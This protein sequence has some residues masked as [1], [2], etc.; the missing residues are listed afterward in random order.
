MTPRTRRGNL[1]VT[2]APSYAAGISDIPLLGETIGDNLARTA[3]QFA[4]SAALVECS[5][6]R[7]WTYREFDAAVDRLALGLLSLDLAAGERLGIWA[8]N[9]AEWVLLQYATARVGVVLVNLNPAYRTHELAYALNQSGCRVIVCA[10]AFKTSNYVEMV[11]AVSGR[12]PR[13]RR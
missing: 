6:G 11:D 13:W 7:R 4:D 5:T 1:R 8:P 10:Q 9:C 2:A 12:C 3:A